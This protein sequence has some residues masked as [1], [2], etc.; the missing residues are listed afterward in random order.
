MKWEGV[1]VMDGEL[2]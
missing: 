1:W 2:G